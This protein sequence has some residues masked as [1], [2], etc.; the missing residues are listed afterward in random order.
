M[1]DWREKDV[2]QTFVTSNNCGF[3]TL[4]TA[5]N[6]IPIGKRCI[7]IFGQGRNSCPNANGFT[8]SSLHFSLSLSFFLVEQIQEVS[9]IN[10]AGEIGQGT[11]LQTS[12]PAAP[13]KRRRR[14]W[15]QQ[16]L[17][18][19][20]ATIAAGPGRGTTVWDGSLSPLPPRYLPGLKAR[21]NG[22]WGRQRKTRQPAPK[23]QRPKRLTF[24]HLRRVSSSEQQ[25][26]QQQGSFLPPLATATKGNN[27][28]RSGIYPPPAGDG[29]QKQSGNAS[30]LA[31]RFSSCCA[32]FRPAAQFRPPPPP[33]RLLLA[34]RST[35]LAPQGQALL[36]EEL[37][38]PS[39]NEI[40]LRVS[41]PSGG[42]RVCSPACTETRWCV[43]RM[44][45]TPVQ[46]HS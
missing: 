9:Y 22:C 43:N 32:S 15:C 30:P 34:P 41:A 24:T 21:R 13:L 37:A 28:P 4:W 2:T 17:S 16:R 11:V 12:Q 23:V 29:A 5:L 18:P 35:A 27:P 14:R 1:K 3:I 6:T 31:A 38:M 42:T 33:P 46:N 39:E 40:K 7:F 10:S 26:Q 20:R 25:Q 36:P 45:T 8:N 19:K 44:Q